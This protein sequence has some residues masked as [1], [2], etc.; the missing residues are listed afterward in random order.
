MVPGEHPLRVILSSFNDKSWETHLQSGDG[1][2]SMVFRWPEHDAASSD[3]WVS[4]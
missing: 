2:L 3:Q 1:V 4:L